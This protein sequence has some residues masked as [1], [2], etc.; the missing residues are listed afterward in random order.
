MTNDNVVEFPG[1]TTN[2]ITP[3]KVLTKA[4]ENNLSSCVVVGWTANDELYLSSSSGEAKEIFL[5]FELA[6]A[7]LLD[8]IR[9]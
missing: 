4:A 8:M 7:E 2:D 3:E 1:T 9:L 5:L 6:R